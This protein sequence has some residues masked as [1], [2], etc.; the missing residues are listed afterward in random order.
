MSIN[1]FRGRLIFR[2]VMVVLLL[3]VCSPSQSLSADGARLTER[4][5]ELANR[6]Q[7]LE[8][9]LLRLA[10]VEAAENPERSA[11]LRRAARQSSDKFVLD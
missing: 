6:Y 9:L 4:Q 5:T 8:E 3:L 7:Q 10:E 2:H 11:L 1:H